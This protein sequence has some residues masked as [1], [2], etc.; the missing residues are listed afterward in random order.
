MTSVI[1]DV[2]IKKINSIK[3]DRYCKCGF[4]FSTF[5]KFHKSSKLKKSRHSS[6][7]K[8]DRILWYAI[9]RYNSV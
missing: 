2:F 8:I 6:L 9:A 1:K 7:W 5:E 4:L 3:R